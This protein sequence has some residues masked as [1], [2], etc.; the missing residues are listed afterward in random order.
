MDRCFSSFLAVILLSAC[1]TGDPGLLR[2]ADVF[3][4]G[5]E[6]TGNPPQHSGQALI[7]RFVGVA[8]DR[9]PVVLYPGLGL[10]S[11]IWMS[12]PDGRDGW[13]QNL[14][15]AGHPTY[16]YDPVNT[17][18]S[19]FPVAD[20]G[21]AT[22]P[23]VSIWSIGQVWRRWG[24]GDRVGEPYPE[25]R[26]PVEQIDQFYAS[27]PARVA[28]AGG[29]GRGGGRGGGG[30]G[31]APVGGDLAALEALL[32]RIGPAVVMPHSMGG[33]TA[34]ALAARRPELFR[35]LVVIEPV[36]CPRTADQVA[37]LAGIPFLAVYGD[38]IESRGQAGRLE[39]CRE[40]A[41]LIR[42]AGGISDVLSLPDE[43][44]RGNTH[45]LMQDDNSAEIV[46][47]IMGWIEKLPRK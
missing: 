46:G 7:H 42:E 30:S 18:P 1:A 26:Y 29:G 9:A 22:P 31:D 19:G 12:T 36:G 45:L 16:T 25:V 5:G 35:A 43:G 39:A 13:A 17:G 34:F 47:R 23:S 14:A 20:F 24:F 28:S 38:Y 6:V 11:V 2:Q 33:Q 21:S 27:W 44:I 4:I 3:H 40:T 32:E 41:R 37:P 8:D 10:S 15:R